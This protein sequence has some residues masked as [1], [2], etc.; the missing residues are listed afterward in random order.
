MHAL[1]HVS[2]S[3]RNLIGIGD[4]F[5]KRVTVALSTPIRGSLSS[6]SYHFIYLHTKFGDSRFS[7]SRGMIACVQTENGLCDPDHTP[8][9]DSLSPAG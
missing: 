7:H 9:T 4:I 6:Q 1:V 5:L 8:F 3:I 2:I